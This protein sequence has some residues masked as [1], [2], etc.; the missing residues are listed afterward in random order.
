MSNKIIYFNIW[1]WFWIGGGVAFLL[2]IWDVTWAC[3]AV[4]DSD[5][6]DG[7]VCVS[8]VGG[9]ADSSVCVS[10]CDGESLQ[11]SRV[12]RGSLWH[13]PVLWL[14]APK[15]VNTLFPA[16]DISTASG[17]NLNALK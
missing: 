13:G 17:V 14:P 9:V 11:R 6:V 5:S 10:E 2:L 3:V 12:S 7:G 4:L 8:A 1:W 15:Q 16:P